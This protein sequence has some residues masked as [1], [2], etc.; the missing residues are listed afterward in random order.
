MRRTLSTFVATVCLLT[1]FVSSA[2]CIAQPAPQAK[3]MTLEMAKHTVGAPEHAC[4]PTKQHSEHTSISC[5]TVHHQSAVATRA[6]DI[7]PSLEMEPANITA[8][9]LPAATVGP[10]SGGK[11]GPPPRRPATKLRI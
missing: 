11:T 2:A 5:C 10:R 3:A 9:L 8:T 1:L 4:C 7:S 6:T